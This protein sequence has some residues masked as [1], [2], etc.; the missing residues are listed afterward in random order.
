MAILISVAMWLISLSMLVMKWSCGTRTVFGFTHRMMLGH[1]PA[2]RSMLLCGT[3]FT[4]IR[5]TAPIFLCRSHKEIVI[6]LE[7]HSLLNCHYE[8]SHWRSEES[9]SGREDLLVIG[10]KR[11]DPFPAKRDRDDNS[12]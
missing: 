12:K 6:L 5:T 11:A 3:R 4:T 7:F 10:N 8:R 1:P 9:A 2:N